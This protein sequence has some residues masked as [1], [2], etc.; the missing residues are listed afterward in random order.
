MNYAP[1]LPDVTSADN[2]KIARVIDGE[3]DKDNETVELPDVNNDDNG[4]ILKVINGAWG[5]GTEVEGGADT[6]ITEAWLEAHLV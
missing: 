2:G 1:Y 5:K 3:W 6:A 4:K